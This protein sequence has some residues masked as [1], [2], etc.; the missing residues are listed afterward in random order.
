MSAHGVGDGRSAATPPRATRILLIE[1]DNVAAKVVT[2][3]LEAHFG[4][5]CVVR[6]AD[7]AQADAADLSK[8]DVALCDY[9]LPD[10]DGIAVTRRMLRRRPDLPVVMLTTEA[11][12]ATVVAAIGAGACDYV[13]KTVDFAAAAAVIVEKNLAMARV[14]RENALLH[15]ALSKSMAELRAKNRDLESAVRQLQQLALTDELT[16]LAN[17]R[18]LNDL[19]PQMYAQ[20]VR[21]GSDLACLMIDLDGFKAINDTLG[22]ARGDDL[23]SLTGEVIRRNIRSSDVG[24]RLGGDEFVVLLPQTPCQTAALLAARLGAAFQREAA[25]LGKV[26]MRCGMSI[27]VSCLALSQ[28]ADG[29]QLLV[30]ADNALYAAKDSGKKRIMVCGPDGVTALEPEA[31]SA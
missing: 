17:R 10:G 26:G 31:L 7:A 6:A 16:G 13:L 28:P 15:D 12:V 3:S 20:A 5:G 30:H 2:Q 11:E 21:Y 27:G 9:H 18:R 24:A 8:V 29:D 22:H 19:L 23:L 1:D 4:A 14:K 25:R